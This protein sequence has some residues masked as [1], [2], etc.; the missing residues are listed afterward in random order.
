MFSNLLPGSGLGFT[1]SQELAFGMAPFFAE[2]IP[3]PIQEEIFVGGGAVGG[4]GFYSHS[5]DAITIY[6]NSYSRRS[7]DNDIVEIL[8]LLFGALE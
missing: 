7:D 3:D 8:S 4:G 2:T 1:G 5:R 6:D